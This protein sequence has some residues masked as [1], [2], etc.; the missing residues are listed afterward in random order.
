[1]RLFLFISL[2]GVAMIL[3]AATRGKN[4]TAALTADKE[5]EITLHE[6]MD[7]FENEHKFLL[8]SI[9]DLQQ[10]MKVESQITSDRFA[11]IEA[12]LAELPK[13]KN[14]KAAAA[15]QTIPTVVFN[16]RY[17]RVV[18]M[19]REGRTPEQ[20]SKDTAIGLGEIQTVLNL[21]KQGNAI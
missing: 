16:E 2:L 12:K 21:A 9:Q 10:Q 1:M 14:S 11:E 6:F 3:F 15:E 20:I 8:Q 17:S 19:A 4:Q 5:L 18:E 13:R 7:E